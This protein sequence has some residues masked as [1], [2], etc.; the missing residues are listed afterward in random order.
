MNIAENRVLFK[1]ILLPSKS[2]PVKISTSAKLIVASVAKT[3]SVAIPKVLLAAFA[4]V[5][6]SLNLLIV[7]IAWILTSVRSLK[8]SAE[9]H[10]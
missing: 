1:T 4:P 9:M 3:P 10:L 8:T 7:L 2:K 6:L 5:V